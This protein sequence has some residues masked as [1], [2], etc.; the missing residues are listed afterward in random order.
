M[1]HLEWARTLP[2]EHLAK[3]MLCPNERL[4]RNSGSG[5]NMSR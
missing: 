2:A 5:A 3:L 4:R 1:T